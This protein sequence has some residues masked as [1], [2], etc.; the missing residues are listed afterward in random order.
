MT[1]EFSVS[2]RS[3]SRKKNVDKISYPAHT[4]W[5]KMNRL[6]CRQ[7]IMCDICGL[8]RP[9]AMQAMAGFAKGCKAKSSS[10]LL[11]GL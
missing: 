1:S 8:P 7:T 11:H 6:A 4:N 3:V 2:P 9:G 10:A 5:A